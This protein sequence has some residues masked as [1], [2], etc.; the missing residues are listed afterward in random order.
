[1][2]RTFDV[3][4]G[5][6]PH[7]A[8]V[9]PSAGADASGVPLIYVTRAALEARIPQLA[10]W[11]QE[12]AATPAPAPHAISGGARVRVRGERVDAGL[13]NVVAAIAGTDPLLSREI[14][15]VGAHLDHEG[16]VAFSPIYF[17]GADDNASGTA[18]LLE[19]AR[20]LA[21]GPAPKRTVVFAAWNGEE[22]GLLGS[23]HYVGGTFDAGQQ[24]QIFPDLAYPLAET[25]AAFSVDMVGAGD[26]TGLLLYNGTTPRASGLAAA[27]QNAAAARGM[28][29][30]VTPRE[31]LDASD[32]VP[33]DRAGIPAVLALSRGDEPAFHAHYHTPSDTPDTLD[34]RDLETSTRVLWAALQRLAFGEADPRPTTATVRAANESQARMSSSTPTAASAQSAVTNAK[35]MAWTERATAGVGGS[36]ITADLQP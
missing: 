16:A 22:R 33:F 30:S 12:L 19:L 6:P 35:R 15:V 4:D 2:S 10:E 36:R 29:S 14:V 31:P 9:L 32:H 26:G 23:R 20:A 11:A 5:P 28:P 18:V 13:D 17:P 8:G 27:V 3:A 24:R 1:V 34:R 7:N 25:V 21:S